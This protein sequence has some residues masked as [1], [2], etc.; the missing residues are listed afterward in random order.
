[1]NFVFNLSYMYEVEN[2]LFTTPAN[3]YWP[4][5]QGTDLPGGRGQSVGHLYQPLS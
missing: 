3:Q 4:N 2:L 5:R 1:M